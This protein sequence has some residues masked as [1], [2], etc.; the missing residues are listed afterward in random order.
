MT[1][2][3]TVVQDQTDNRSAT[4]PE[5][6]GLTTELAMARLVE[7]A[8]KLGASDLLL[9]A[10]E[11]YLAI[12][13]RRLGL[14]EPVAIVSPDKGKAFIQHLKAEAGMDVAELRRP[15]DGRWL[16]EF[17]LEGFDH[18]QTVDL[19]L[20]TLPTLHGEDMVIRLLDR[21]QGLFNLDD[22]GMTP[23]ELRA[24]QRMIHS[25]GGLILCTGPTA[26]GKSSTLY[27]TL[28]A[29]H[30]G[31]RKINTIEDPVEF[32]VDGLRQSQTQPGIGLTFSKLLRAVLRQSP[33][34][35]MIGEIRDEETA[36]TAVRAANSGHL[37]LSTLHAPVADA[38]VESMRGLGVPDHFLASALRGVVTQRLLRTLDPD[39]RISFDLDHAPEVFASVRPKLQPGEGDKLYAP[40][41]AKGPAGYASRAGVFE[42]LEVDANIRSLIAQG[43]EANRIRA[44]AIDA[45]MTPFRDNALVKVAQGLTSIE[46]VYRVI[47]SEY[48][49]DETPDR[50]AAA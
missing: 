49:Q 35:I 44:A 39:H 4:P 46:E 6:D 17:E 34:V 14:V 27:A 1:A 29:L 38:A 9:L 33:D 36:H 20:S 10:H 37:V 23:D 42:V 15:A 47:P 24:Y 41:P 2:E 13:M 5:L 40:D 7:H 19:R 45:G 3:P 30:D 8:A 16:Y 26:S 43:A 28:A 50:A 22:L 11:D 25:P 18:N 31:Q 21:E 32:A 48:L 12:Q